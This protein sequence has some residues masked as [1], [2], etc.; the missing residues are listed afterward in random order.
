MTEPVINM[1]TVEK[2]CLSNLKALDP[3]FFTLENF[4]SGQGKI[5]IDCYGKAWSGY[6]GSMGT[7][8]IADFLSGCDEFYVAGKLSDESSS[9]VDYDKLSEVIGE[10]VERETLILYSDKMT[11]EYGPDWMID[12][13]TTENPEYAYLLR[14][15]R[16]VL[17]AIKRNLFD[18][19]DP[20]RDWIDIEKAV[21]KSSSKAHQCEPV[22]AL[23]EH[24]KSSFP[25]WDPD[26]WYAIRLE[27]V[28]G[29]VEWWGVS[30]DGGE[31]K[32]GDVVDFQRIDDCGARVTKWKR[33]HVN[34]K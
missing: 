11:A 4:G 17:D 23:L 15:V 22:L 14:I 33:I 25:D 31:L 34:K 32:E 21:P 10:S 1:L 29:A 3:V 16:A 19:S 9:I 6:F 13:P 27:R 24:D 30:H 7:D 18:Y 8:C 28:N 2:Y 26:E 5:T 12:L 20:Y